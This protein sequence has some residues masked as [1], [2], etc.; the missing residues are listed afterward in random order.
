VPKFTAR[1]QRGCPCSL[2]PVPSLVCERHSR[3][4]QTSCCFFCLCAT[5]ASRIG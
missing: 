5:A 3:S 1:V 2:R 4:G